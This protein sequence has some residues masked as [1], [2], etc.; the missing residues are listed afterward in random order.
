MIKTKIPNFS[1]FHR[2]L[3]QGKENKENLKY[4]Y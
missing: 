3:L 4:H 2:V 1:D